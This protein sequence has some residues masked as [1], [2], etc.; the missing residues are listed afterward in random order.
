M[1][2]GEGDV[3]EGVSMIHSFNRT[4]EKSLHTDI[5]VEILVTSLMER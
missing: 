3:D 4:Q 5:V 1:T 2:A